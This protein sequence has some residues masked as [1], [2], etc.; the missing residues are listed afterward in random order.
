MRVLC[1][2]GPDPWRDAAVA[3]HHTH[4]VQDE[5]Q[6]LMDSVSKPLGAWRAT[7][8]PRFGGDRMGKAM[9]QVMGFAAGDPCPPT[10][11]LNPTELAALKEV[12]RGFGWPVAG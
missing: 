10:M 5:A 3:S 6:K 8:N 7:L 12:L 4:S 11:P 9:L 2:L 1:S